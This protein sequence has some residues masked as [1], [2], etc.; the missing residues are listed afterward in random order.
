MTKLWGPLGWMSL[1]SVSLIY[2]EIP[3]PSDIATV[4]RFLDLFV[5]TIACHTCKSHFTTI[6]SVYT[7]IHPE[8]LNSRQDF[9]MFIFRAHNTVNRRLDKPIYSSVSECVQAIQL[10]TRDTSLRTFRQ[11]YMEYLN[12]NWKKFQTGEGLIMLN[13]TKALKQINDV[14]WNKLDT[15]APIDLVEGN[16][17]EFIVG[18]KPRVSFF[19]GRTITTNVGFKGGKLKLRRL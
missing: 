10:A 12:S 16:V 14:Y 19:T 3:T 1:H 13:S 17:L 7:Q 6:Y 5:E 8:Y 18:A 2:P 15:D 9:S 4:K 11:K